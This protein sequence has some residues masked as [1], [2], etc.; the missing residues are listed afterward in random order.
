MKICKVQ[1]FVSV[2]VFP[3]L[4]IVNTFPALFYNFPYI[5]GAGSLGTAFPPTWH[6]SNKDHSREMCKMEKKSLVVKFWPLGEVRFS[7]TQIT[8]LTDAASCD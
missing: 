3:C 6:F 5:A 2:Y 8:H 4:L 7:L 1:Y